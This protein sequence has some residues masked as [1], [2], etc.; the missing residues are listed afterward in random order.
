MAQ[1]RHLGCDKR[2]LVFLSAILTGNPP[3]TPLPHIP[4]IASRRRPN[5]GSQLETNL[6]LAFQSFLRKD[7]STEKSR[8]M[9]ALLKSHFPSLKPVPS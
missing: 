4:H 8:P 2:R 9:N 6:Q 5:T 7:I 1:L 3:A